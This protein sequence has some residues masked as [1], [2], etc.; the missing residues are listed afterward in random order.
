MEEQTDMV[1][2]P[3]ILRARRKRALKEVLL[4]ASTT[5]VLGLLFWQLPVLSTMWMLLAQFLLCL[6]LLWTGA[7][8]LKSLALYLLDFGEYRHSLKLAAH[9]EPGSTEL[10]RRELEGA[11]ARYEAVRERGLAMWRSLQRRALGGLLLV[12][13]VVGSWKGSFALAM[14]YQ[15]LEVFGAWIFMASLLMGMASL[16]LGAKFLKDSNELRVE[17]G[18]QRM[19]EREMKI[20][21]R[22]TGDQVGA[23]SVA[24]D[25]DQGLRGALT[26]DTTR[27]GISQT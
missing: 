20:V 16:V 13:L 17:L 25:E 15:E 10:A 8:T 9:A 26:Q 21:Q 1:A 14:A 19:I 3:E 24:T 18:E 6:L 5:L 27:G 7:V 2:R 23:L 12:G 4:Y 22:S 11:M